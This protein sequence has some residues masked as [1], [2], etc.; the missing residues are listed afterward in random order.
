MEKCYL[1]WN[2]IT[3]CSK[4][5]TKAIVSSGKRFDYIIGIPR[6]GLIPATILSHKLK[7]PMINPDMVGSGQSILVVDDISDTGKT[8]QKVS[9]SN[10]HWVKSHDVCYT[11]VALYMRKGS[12]FKP[13]HVAHQIDGNGWVIFPWESDEFAKPESWDEQDVENL[14]M[15]KN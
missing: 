5:L 14:L 2:D 10:N 8:F 4:M 11:Y 13:D 15:R 1:T 7:I 9:C 12:S 3:T 6:G